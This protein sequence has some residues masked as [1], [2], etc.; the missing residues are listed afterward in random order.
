MSKK[1]NRHKW[2]RLNVDTF[3]CSLCSAYLEIIDLKDI[4]IEHKN[5]INM[6]KTMFKNKYYCR[7]SADNIRWQRYVPCKSE[8]RFKNILT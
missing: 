2:T 4:Y 5:I 8:N 3:K 7:Y 1:L 6:P